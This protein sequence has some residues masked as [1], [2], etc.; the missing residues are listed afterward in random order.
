MAPLPQKPEAEASSLIELLEHKEAVAAPLL[1]ANERNERMHAYKHTVHTYRD[2]RQTDRQTCVDMDDR[3]TDGQINGQRDGW[4]R[5]HTQFILSW[6][7]Y[8]P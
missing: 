2:Y 8:M 6:S 3:P 4:T 7:A 5:T 1:I